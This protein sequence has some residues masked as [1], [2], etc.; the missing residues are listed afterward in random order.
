MKVQHL[1]NSGFAI[2]S[3][4]VLLSLACTLLLSL[5]NFTID[6]AKTLKAENFE[7]TLESKTSISMLEKSLNNK[8]LELQF[9]TPNREN[10]SNREYFYAV[11][12]KKISPH[13]HFPH[14]DAY[15]Q[16][17]PDWSACKRWENASQSLY[18]QRTCKDISLHSNANLFIIDGNLSLNF[19]LLFEKI[20]KKKLTLIVLGSLSLEKGLHLKEVKDATFEIL[21]AGPVDIQSLNTF[22]SKNISIL[23]FSSRQT[24]SIFETEPE[25]HCE[26]DDIK[27]TIANNGEFTG[28]PYLLSE[29]FFP[30]HV[31]LGKARL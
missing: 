2:L 23:I 28:C 20:Q 3:I 18:A 26:P 5:K 11:K 24:K 12:Q 6:G 4:L 19:E 25:I 9:I 8:K 15:L 16:S 27:V 7:K 1:N 14:W 22:N 30:S 13:T 17:A 29:Y 10:Q 21:S 31:V